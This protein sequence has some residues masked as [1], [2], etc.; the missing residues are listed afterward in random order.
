[1]MLFV[2]P[3]D[4]SAVDSY[5]GTSHSSITLSTFR[6]LAISLTSSAKPALSP[7]SKAIR[8]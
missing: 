1:M 2:L 8:G 7:C 6:A 4:V 3:I 5:W